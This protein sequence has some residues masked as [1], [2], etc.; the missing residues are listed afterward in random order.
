MKTSF[1][2][3]ISLGALVLFGLAVSQ[4]ASA[5]DEY[6]KNEQI[7]TCVAAIGDRADYSGADRVVHTVTR[8][9]QR[10]Y[11]ELEIRVDTSVYGT[12]DV[13]EYAASC[14]THTLGDIV[15]L[16]VHPVQD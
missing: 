11:A 5:N 15:R 10:N 7:E 13:R 8:L 4:T 9:R 2:Q 14:V 3:A 12:E 1:R 16:R 6:R